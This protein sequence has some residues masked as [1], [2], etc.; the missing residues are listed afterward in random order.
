[1]VGLA[2]V[3]AARGRV[4]VASEPAPDR[5]DLAMMQFTAG[6]TGLPKGVLLTH[7]NLL[8]NAEGVT[9]HTSITAADRLLH[10]M[11][12]HHTNGVNNQLVVP[13]IAG[14]TV[15]LADKFRAEEI[16]SLIARH[17]ITY[18]TGVPTMY[19]RIIPHLSVPKRLASLR[20]LRCGSAPITVDLHRQIE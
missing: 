18:V 20:F 14:A 12:L 10:L 9:A 19:A 3:R 8:C 6:S 17:R 16:E 13:F 5:G 4:A 7:A 1:T 11:P 2:E 15:V